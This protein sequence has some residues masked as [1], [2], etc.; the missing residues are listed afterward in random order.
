MNVTIMFVIPQKPHGARLVVF[1][2]VYFVTGF[3]LFTFSR[4]VT[5]LLTAGLSRDSM[6]KL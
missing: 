3:Y 5:G 1:E 2:Y 4:Y 6:T